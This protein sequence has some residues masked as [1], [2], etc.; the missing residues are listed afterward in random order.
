MPNPYVVRVDRNAFWNQFRSTPEP[1]LMM[2]RP[3]M[4][5][6]E[7]LYRDRWTMTGPY[8]GQSFPPFAY[9]DPPAPSPIQQPFPDGMFPNPPSDMPIE[10]LGGL[11]ATEVSSIG[12][13]PVLAAVVSAYHGY[14][15]HDDDPKWAAAWGLGSLAITTLATPMLWPV[16]PAAAVLQGYGQREAFQKGLRDEENDWKRMKRT[17]MFGR[18][19]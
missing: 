9:G 18:A 3:P 14:K 10:G 6:E 13:L 16:V 7:P 8:A 19:R 12:V 11:G 1:A 5:V 17:S 4:I 15:R 2:R